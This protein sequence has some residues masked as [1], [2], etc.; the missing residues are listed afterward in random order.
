MYVSRATKCRRSARKSSIGAPVAMTTASAVRTT[1]IGLDGRRPFAR[2][3]SAG[4]ACARG[5]RAAR[6]RRGGEADARPVGIER[7]P[8]SFESR[9]CRR[10]RSRVRAL[11]PSTRRRRGRRRA[12][13]GTPVSAAGR[14]RRPAREENQV[15]GREVTPDGQPPNAP[16]RSRARR[17]C[18][19]ARDV[20][21]PAGHGCAA[22][23]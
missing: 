3:G 20:G 8:P 7:R 22:V 16:P 14:P 21:R 4:P 15:L 19:S 1:C 12:V 10:E 6:G 2:R 11:R 18:R 23:S 5:E 13:P 9:R 17:A